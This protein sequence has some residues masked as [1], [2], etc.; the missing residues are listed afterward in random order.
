MEVG[1]G[2]DALASTGGREQR[3]L[4]AARQSSDGESLAV[5][6]LTTIGHRCSFN[7]TLLMGVLSLDHQYVVLLN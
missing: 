6:V 4:D 7:S 1:M 2:L 5:P 3:F